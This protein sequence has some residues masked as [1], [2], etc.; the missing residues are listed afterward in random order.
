[1]GYANILLGKVDPAG[2]LPFTWGRKLADYPATDP[3]YPERSAK[4]V[5]GKT[6][7]SEGIF[8]GYRWFDRQEVEPLYPFGYGLSYTTF[9]YSA[10]KT[11][12]A[13]DG[14][15]DVS[16]NL[17]NIGSS[18]GDE[19]PQIYLDAPENLIQH[20]QFAPHSLIAFD[21]VHLVPG[22]SQTLT[23]HVPLRALQCWS[24][25]DAQWKLVT[26]PR[27]VW[28][29]GSSRD[30]RLSETFNVEQSSDEKQ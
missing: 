4:G 19:V 20:A 8:V 3:A 26:G 10:L 16:L 27:R 11:L 1:M 22:Q 5:N 17:K 24:S 13:K 25:A 2:R 15:L 23:L 28:A 6:I 18:P 14:G 29:G 12:V 30:V 21:R 7:F 9:K